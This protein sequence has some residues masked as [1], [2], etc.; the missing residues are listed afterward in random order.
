MYIYI[1]YHYYYYHYHHYHDHRMNFNNSKIVSK[2]NIKR[3]R[4]VEVALI[5]FIPKV[6]GNKSFNSLYFLNSRLVSKEAKLLNFVKAANDLA[7]LP[8]PDNP[9]PVSNPR[10]TNKDMQQRNNYR[11]AVY[12]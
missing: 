3:R 12:L 8:N 9:I 2:D 5:D 7:L 11:L 10:D 1:Y 6:L 4:A